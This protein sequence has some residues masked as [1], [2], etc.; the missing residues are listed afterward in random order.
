MPNK[1]ATHNQKQQF[2][3]ASYSGPIPSATEML[4]YERAC[5][6]I[7]DRIMTM[8]EKQMDHRQK[9]ETIAIKTSSLNS[10][11]GVDAQTAPKEK[12]NGELIEYYLSFTKFCPPEDLRGVL[13]YFNIGMK[14]EPFFAVTDMDRYELDAYHIDYRRQRP[15]CLSWGYFRIE[16]RKTKN[17]DFWSSP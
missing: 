4:G 17:F 1:P 3:A 7:A 9:I 8:S 13:I 11:L 2:I 10:C 16:I 6:G 15:P 14:E 12:R 5:P